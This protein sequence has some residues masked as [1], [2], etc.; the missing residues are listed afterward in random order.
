MGSEESHFN[1]LLIARD[2]V[3]RQ[4]PQ[5]TTFLKKK[6]SRS[7]IEPGSFRL[8]A[9]RLTARPN[10]LTSRSFRW[11][12][13]FVGFYFGTRSTPH[14]EHRFLAPSS[15]KDVVTQCSEFGSTP[16]LPPSTQKTPVILPK[17]QVS[18]YI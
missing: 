18:S 6:E 4:Y 15:R 16:V 10:R 7:G 11:G 5:T 14:S 12:M 9:Y 1:V 17:V 3:T 2:K 13:S 8:T